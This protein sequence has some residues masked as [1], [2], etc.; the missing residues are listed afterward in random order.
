MEIVSQ[1][2]KG[3]QLFISIWPRE[4]T[5]NMFI[6]SIVCSVVCTWGICVYSWHDPSVQVSKCCAQ[7]SVCPTEM[8]TMTSK[9]KPALNWSR[10]GA[11][12]RFNTCE[13]AE[14]VTGVQQCVFMS[15]LYI[16]E[17]VRK[18]PCSRTHTEILLFNLSLF[19]TTV[20]VYTCLAM[21]WISVELLYKKLTKQHMS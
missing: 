4:A 9:L 10:S 11:F 15:R 1:L 2:F 16:H 3:W 21:Y 5:G 8:E 7:C 14:R 13:R 20:R 12:S 17:T 19:C 18:L 6:S